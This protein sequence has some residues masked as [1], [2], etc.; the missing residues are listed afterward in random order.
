MRM[1]LPHSILALC[2]L[3]LISGTAAAEI[4]KREAACSS[5]LVTSGDTCATLAAKCGITTAELADYNTNS[6]SCSNPTVGK[7]VCCSSGTLELPPSKGSDGLCYIYTLQADDTCSRIAD[8][9]EITVDDVEVYNNATYAWNGCDDLKQGSF[10]CLSEGSPP[11]PAALPDAICGPQVPGTVR[12]SNMSTLDDLNPC[13]ATG[14]K[15]NLTVGLCYNTVDSKSSCPTGTTAATTV[16]V[17]TT[18]TKST[19]TSTK[20]KT[21]VHSTSTSTTSTKLIATSTKTT[22]TLSEKETTASSTT[23]VVEI[24]RLSWTKPTTTTSTTSKVETTTSSTTHTSSTSALSET[25]T[26]KDT[27]TTATTKQTSTS[28]STSP[29]STS[30]YEP[31]QIA[32]YS[33]EGCEGDYYLLSGSNNGKESAC[34]D[35]HGGLSSVFTES[36]T[37]CRWFTNGGS[38]S[39]DCD[40]G[41][42]TTPASWYFTNAICTVYPSSNCTNTDGT[43][44]GYSSASGFTKAPGCTNF[45]DDTIKVSPWGSFQCNTVDATNI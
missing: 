33:E 7:P 14:C 29:A 4:H 27:T 35:L 39:T 28:T 1:P 38:D 45:A 23:S 2:G 6:T 15:C 19:A 9:Y 10:I 25:T 21:T 42:M 16:A 13:L 34:L 36:G 17:K 12:P 44:Q 43:A 11:M 20:A 31:W 3:F 22:S 37:W 30:S 8:G 5:I 18:S 24:T 26:H 40:A 41:T 32:M